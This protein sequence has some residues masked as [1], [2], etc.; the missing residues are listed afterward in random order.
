[1]DWRQ[2]VLKRLA[3]GQRFQFFCLTQMEARHAF[4]EF[5]CFL[6]TMS[7]GTKTWLAH[8]VNGNLNVELVGGGQVWFDSIRRGPRDGMTCLFD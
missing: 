1:M 8:G 4:S 3:E 5:V 6:K 7:L 2:E